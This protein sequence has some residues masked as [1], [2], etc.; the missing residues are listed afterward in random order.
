MHNMRQN[1]KLLAEIRGIC[2]STLSRSGSLKE[3]VFECLQ[4]S[5]LAVMRA[6]FN[7]AGGRAV[8]KANSIA[9]DE[10]IRHLYE[11][12]VERRRAH[13]RTFDRKFCIIALGGYG[14]AELS[15]KSDIDIL[16]LYADKIGN[17]LKT[18]TVDAVMYPLWDTGL[19]LGHSS[20]TVAET[21][22]DAKGDILFRNSLLDARLICGS[23]SLYNRFSLRL[24]LLCRRN[25][26]EH[27]NELMRLKRD[28]HAK[29]GWTP[30]LQEPNIKNGIGGLRD[31]QTMQ[32]KTRLNFGRGDI[33]ELVRRRKLS[34][35][36]FKSVMNAYDF[37][38][39]VR[40]DMHYQTGRA[41][42]LLDL[43][44]Q[45]KI[46]SHFIHGREGEIERVE[47]FMRK[48]YF[49]FR[50]IDTVTKT[51]R[52]RMRIVLPGDVLDTM[53][54]MGDKKILALSF[55]KDGF[56]FSNGVASALSPHVFRHDP[57]RLIKIFA[58]CQR[59]NDVPD[60]RLEVRIKDSVHLITD[61]VREDPE[62]NEVFLSILENEGEVFPALEPM[63]YWGVLGMFVP[64]FQE[65]T[66]MVQH[67]FYHRYTADVHILNTIEQLD[68]IFYAGPGDELYWEY[69]KVITGTRSPAIA[70][71]M[72]F[73]HDIG[74]GDGIRGHA[75]VGAEI[76]AKLLRRF[77]VPESEI[78]PILFVVRNHLEMARFWQSNDIED[79]KA[80]AKFARLVENE[81]NLKYLY[82]ITFCDSMGTTD[83]FWNSYKQSLHSMLYRAA[84]AHIQK[85][86][87]QLA[88]SYERRKMQVVHEVLDMPE[89]DGL[90]Q[91]LM[92]H[93]E[94]L[95][96]NYFAYHGRSDLL[97]H[98]KMVAE[99]LEETE[100]NPLVPHPILEWR[101]DPNSSISRLCVVSSD[102]LG[103]FPIITGVLTLSGL[104]ILASK[105]MTRSD[106]ITLDTYWVTGISGGVKENPRFR[107]RFAKNVYAAL[108]E[109]LSLS[110]EINNM[111]YSDSRGRDSDMVTD[112]FMRHESGRL[113]VE[114]RAPDREGLLYK[115]ARR[116][117]ACGYEIT[118]ARINTVGKWAQDVFYLE[119]LPHADSPE[120]LE[121]YIK[122]IF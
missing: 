114:V 118:F 96:R 30:Y 117:Q 20:R 34:L 32:W 25:R 40:N 79:E 119:A 27:F 111:F 84:L 93:V 101:D 104:N 80:I 121:A 102:R 61:A 14:R 29:F 82:V 99:L 16:F 95:P 70:Y 9:V 57:A 98:V 83:G 6:H 108:S 37:L 24:S 60:D 50:A 97:M 78:E 71:L 72:L 58:Y 116:I 12:M 28:R 110:E 81:D 88:Q 42:D 76:G 100:K 48:V 33:R 31:F 55:K 91:L 115:I 49:A 85:A 21:L 73:L 11:I 26:K 74:K 39:R 77:N 22:S 47:T 3:S 109:K 54:H 53:R 43:E 7:G 19:K 107:E 1:Q 68:K 63:H 41:T 15:P 13:D 67:E 10:I 59:F 89:I 66:C 2:E 52:K 64:E 103:L 92:T 44:L 36:E 69:H 8:C 87:D 113:I 51:A 122:N 94:N 86:D 56:K 38:L 62:T 35:M 17:E 5:V 18:L 106:N 75:E 105:I 112:V 65:I 45:V 23:Q 120:E 4:Q 46:A 90:E